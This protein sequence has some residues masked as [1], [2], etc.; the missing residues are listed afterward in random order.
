[1]HFW[2]FRVYL[3]QFPLQNKLKIN[4]QCLYSMCLINTLEQVARNIYTYLLT[5]CH[6]DNTNVSIPDYRNI[7]CIH[8]NNT[9]VIQYTEITLDTF[10]DFRISHCKIAYFITRETSDTDR[11][12]WL[13]SAVSVSIWTPPPIHLG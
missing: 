9:Q 1:M 13:F 10:D 4:N 12:I 7:I 6:K 3:A 5:C 2:L 8:K 11:I